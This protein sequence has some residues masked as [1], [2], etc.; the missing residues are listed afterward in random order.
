[1]LGPLLF[2]VYLNDLPQCVTSSHTQLFADDCLI[3]KVIWPWCPSRMG[4]A[5][6]DEFPSTEM[7]TATN[8]QKEISS[9]G[10]LRDTISYPIFVHGIRVYTYPESVVSHEAVGRMWYDWFRVGINPYPV[11]KHGITIL[12]F[13]HELMKTNL[14][15]WMV[16][17]I[18]LININIII[19]FNLALST[20]RQGKIVCY[21]Q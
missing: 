14:S 5:V 8:H 13:D 6:D 21:P 9:E 20:V 3:Y 18:E 4:T 15:K 12:S 2:L 7:P 11:N 17:H 10:I 1:M 16:T 19:I